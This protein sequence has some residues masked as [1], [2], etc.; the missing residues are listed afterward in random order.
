MH[1]RTYIGIIKQG[2][3]DTE[4]QVF[5]RI[6]DMYVHRQRHLPIAISKDDRTRR[7]LPIQDKSVSRASST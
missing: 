4:E 7:K 2:S 3:R 5:K 6:N 1:M